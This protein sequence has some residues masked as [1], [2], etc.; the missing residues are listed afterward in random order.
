M[1]TS[2]KAVIV[3][4]LVAALIGVRAAIN[5]LGSPFGTNTPRQTIDPSAAHLD[6]APRHGGLVLMN[7]DTHF[8]VL[9]DANWIGRVYFT[10]AV[11]EE[12]PP[13]YASLVSLTIAGDSRRQAIA[14]TLDK[15][16][17]FWVGNLEPVEDP[18]AIVRVFYETRGA[19]PYWIDLPLSSVRGGVPMTPPAP[20]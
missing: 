8:E 20:P 9:V 10:D 13:T 14:L 17:N 12:L 3:L 15:A 6:H 1:T 5:V 2:R 16:R 19:R 7:E 18:N 4:G 11:R